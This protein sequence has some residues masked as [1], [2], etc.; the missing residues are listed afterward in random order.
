MDSRDLRNAGVGV[1]WNFSQNIRNNVNGTLSGVRGDNS[2][3]IFGPDLEELEQTADRMVRAMQKVRGMEDVGVFHIM[4]QS[5]LNLP[6]DRDKCRAW[7][8]NVGDVQAVVDTAVGGKAFSQM[9]EGER[10]FDITLRCP[11]RAASN[12]DAIL[13]I[14]VDVSK[15]TVVNSQ[16]IRTGGHAG[17]RSQQRPVAD[18]QQRRLAPLDRQSRSTPPITTSAARRAAGWAT[19]SRPWP[20]RPARRARLVSAARGLGHLPRAGRA[21]DRR[22]IRRPQPRPGRRRGRG[23]ARQP[24]ACARPLPARLG[25]RIPGDGR[26]R[27]ALDGHYPLGRWR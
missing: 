16:S 23:Q 26:G 21:A 19:W 20:R 18:R 17:Q 8:L 2:V 15:N 10:S 12:L 1:D 22:Q 11:Q 24:R 7:N 13:E 3:K 14:P 6:V 4:G 9:I 5:N 27:R 25:R